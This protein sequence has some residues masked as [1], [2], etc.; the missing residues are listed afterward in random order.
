MDIKIIQ[1]TKNQFKSN[2]SN[3]AFNRLYEEFNSSNEAFNSSIE[4]KNSSNQQK[5]SS[6]EQKNSSNEQQIFQQFSTKFIVY[7]GSCQRPGAAA[8]YPSLAMC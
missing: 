3:E 4:L 8:T 5:S 6:Y 7:K 2:S 1:M